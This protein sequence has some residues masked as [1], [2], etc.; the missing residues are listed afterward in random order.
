MAPATMF[1]RKLA[2][3]PAQLP[4][5]TMTFEPGVNVIVGP[6]NAGKTQWLRILDHLFG[7][8]KSAEKVF[9]GEVFENY[10]TTSLTLS[11]NGEDYTIER[12][13]KEAR[14][15]TKIFMNG[16]SLSCKDFSHKVLD[17]LSI[18]VV[19]YPQGNPYSPRA[20]PELGL[21]SL[22]RHVYRQQRFWSDL[23]DKQPESEQH[24]CLMQFLGVAKDLFS[25]EYG[26]LIQNS[27][28]IDRLKLKK[29]QF[30]SVLQ[31]ISGELIDV[32][33]LGVSLTPQSIEM[34]SNRMHGEIDKLVERRKEVLEG[35]M[36]S[37]APKV[38]SKQRISLRNLG[39]KIVSLQAERKDLV[40]MR[41]ALVER[42]AELAEYERLVEE[43]LARV[44]RAARAGE[45]LSHIKITHCPAC[46]RVIGQSN[47]HTEE[48]VLCHR[49]LESSTDSNPPAAKR[50]EFERHQL[51]AELNEAT[52]LIAGLHRK[53]HE[54]D[55]Q[56]RK[57]DERIHQVHTELR[58]AR[59]AAA[60]I[61][62][63]E[64]AVFD[65]EI[66][67]VEE[68]LQQVQRI[69]TSLKKRED[70]SREIHE[71]E[72][73]VARLEA[74][75]AEQKYL[76]DLQKESDEF[77]DAMNTYLNLIQTERP[78][79]WSQNAVLVGFGR[80]DFK[81]SVGSRSWQ[82]KLGGTATLTFLMAYHYGLMC[83]TNRNKYNYPG[84]LILD[85]PASFD[86]GSSVREEESFVLEPFAK[87]LATSEMAS[88][89][90]I[91]A[92][93][94]FENLEDANRIELD[95]IWK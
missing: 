53:R 8:D 49:P 43:E 30:L 19:H 71:V 48:C 60:A 87:L 86:D 10:E 38:D 32:E 56:I 78:L 95:H 26:E 13:W 69:S 2:R 18:P 37:V 33:D 16:D 79:L 7:Y 51:A 25:A 41:E 23:A 40:S 27:R 22:L 58:P 63:P 68:R 6:Q 77:A 17:L 64:I 20:W 5:D 21:R 11:I 4:C 31:D 72:K 80:R 24:A 34:A 47:S 15:K 74:E 9:A 70:I 39:E 76:V 85:F 57:I 75:V 92:G 81:F 42:L 62:P 59:E 73:E 61:L 35:L 12:R 29:E 28:K 88:A 89:Q 66:G 91:A 65:M 90:V 45:T 82:S 52:E 93:R 67:R 46:D 83:L 1:I 84:L 94:S 50:V 44:D 36:K 14:S 55:S 54:T 3:Y